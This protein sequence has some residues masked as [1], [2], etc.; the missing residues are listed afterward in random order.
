MNYNDIFVNPDNETRTPLTPEQEAHLRAKARSESKQRRQPH[1][2]RLLWQYVPALRGRA[3][4]EYRRLS[5]SVNIDDVRSNVLAG[6]T[7]AVYSNTSDLS[8]GQL[9]ERSVFRAADETNQQGV[10]T[11]P[12]Q[13]RREF[14]NAMFEAD[15]NLELAITMT[16]GVLSETSMRTLH[17]AL[18]GH[19]NIDDEAF[20]SS[21][22]HDPYDTIDDALDVARALTSLALGAAGT[23]DVRLVVARAFGLG[24]QSP[25]SDDAIADELRRAAPNTHGSSDRK[26]PS[27]ATVQRIRKSA[28]VAMHAALCDGADHRCNHAH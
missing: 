20:H 28:L 9:L 7:D 15:G 6:F 27:R 10:M 3:A 14:S 25:A 2:E 8:L 5:G 23:T 4:S 11:I 1:F 13:R 22:V 16:R 21:A 26:T 17:N 19:A 12:P 24:G 18:S